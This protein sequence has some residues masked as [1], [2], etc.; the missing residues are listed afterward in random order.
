MAIAKKEMVGN[1]QFK[2]GVARLGVA[3][4]YQLESSD[5]EFKK[6]DKNCIYFC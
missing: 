5:I 2:K 3:K 6:P 4:A 1:S